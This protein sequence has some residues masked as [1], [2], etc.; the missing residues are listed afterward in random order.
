MGPFYINK[1][2][3]KLKHVTTKGKILDSGQGKMM[4]ERRYQ[5]N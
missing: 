3:F 5:D 1:L 4:Y 2:Y